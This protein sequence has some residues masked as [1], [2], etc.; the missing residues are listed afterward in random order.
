MAG[1]LF[2]EDLSFDQFQLLTDAHGT[3]ARHIYHANRGWHSCENVLRTRL[4]A[5]PP[6]SRA[7]LPAHAYVTFSSADRAQIAAFVTASAINKGRLGNVLDKVSRPRGLV[8]ENPHL[9]SWYGPMATGLDKVDLLV[10]ALN[11]GNVIIEYYKFNGIP[12]L[13]ARTG[14]G[15][16]TH[17]E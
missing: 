2:I 9:S 7:G 3:A 5:G 1:D 10:D 12:I 17:D 14:A 15:W 11:F 8:S 16:A 4:Q 13:S 6:S